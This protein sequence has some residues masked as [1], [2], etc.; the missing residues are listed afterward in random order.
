MEVET[1]DQS[2]TNTN[3]VESIDSEEEQVQREPG[4]FYHLADTV[5]R[6]DRAKTGQDDPPE[7]EAWA[8]KVAPNEEK[9]GQIFSS[10]RFGASGTRELAGCCESCQ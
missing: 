7:S 1:E 4:K 6:A 5:S 10:W 2:Q 3:E 9:Y 8:L